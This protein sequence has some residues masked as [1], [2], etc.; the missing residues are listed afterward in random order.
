MT[1][2][3]DEVPNLL[4]QATIERARQ[5]DRA[6]L[7]LPRGMW[8]SIREY[9]FRDPSKEYACYLL[10]GQ[11]VVS[12]TLRLL[13][14]FLVLPEEEDYES[15]SL[16]GVRLSRRLL[17]E[18]LTECERHS[19]SLI[20]IHSHPFASDTVFFSGTDDAD[21]KE[22]ADWFLRHLPHAFYGSVVLAKNC[23]RARLRT[24]DRSISEVDLDTRSLDLPLV[25]RRDRNLNARRAP[26]GA[27]VDRHVRAFGR[28]GQERL[29]AARIS[30][31][32]VGG[33]GS[34]LAIG[35]AQLGVTHFTLIDPDRADLTNLN[36]V[37]GMTAAD[38]KLGSKKV[39]VTARAILQINPKVKLRLLEESI[40]HERAWSS[41]LTSDLIIA[42]TDN[43]ASRM[44]LNAFSQVYLIPQ[45]SVGA[46]IESKDNEIL[47]G[48]GH[49]FVMLPGHSQQCLLCSQIINPVEAYY[50]TASEA[51]RDEA[52]RRGY[53]NN[54][55]VPAPAVV[56][57]NG[58]L[59]NLALVEIHNLFCGFKEPARY[60]LYDLLEQELLHVVDDGP[61]C[62][63]CSPGGG[64]FGRG[65]RSLVR[66]LFREFGSQ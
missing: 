8:K 48:Y 1:R 62:A 44:L 63:V 31:V 24:A 14:C 57:L 40:L 53:I 47:G 21:E 19:L 15:H 7:V 34:G 6:E 11:C 45:V 30:I 52:A 39:E 12:R 36:R 5:F 26:L 13:G 16:T 65:A 2:A 9:L 55:D 4:S 56:H 28:D 42:A 25:V 41:L 49:V 17:I 22:K 32:G 58:V 54:A 66:N 64:F 3:S 61:Q 51:H 33:L 35:L 46:L 10:C 43:H 23:H 37:H 27:M 38:A 59:Q 18:V 20:D 50:E 60:L 29:R